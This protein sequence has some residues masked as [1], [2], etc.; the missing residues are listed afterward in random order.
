MQNQ[1]NK[2]QRSKKKPEIDLFD[3]LVVERTN[4]FKNI[5]RQYGLNWNESE[6]LFALKQKMTMVYDDFKTD[7][8]ELEKKLAAIHPH[9]NWMLKTLKL[10]PD[11]EKAKPIEFNAK[12]T[13]PIVLESNSAMDGNNKSCA[14]GCGSMSSFDGSDNARKVTLKPQDNPLMWVS[15][16]A[17]VG[18]TFYFISKK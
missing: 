12:K 17:V 1:N 5:L 7:K 10:G 13:G 18:I 15:L 9:K 4:D 2:R 14:C 3:L 6:G 16:V 11:Y 8:I